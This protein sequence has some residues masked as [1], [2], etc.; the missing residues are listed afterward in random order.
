MSTPIEHIDIPLGERHTPH[1]WEYADKATREAATGMVPEDIGRW[2]K[3]LDDG[4]CWELTDDSPVTWQL[5][6][7]VIPQ[8]IK[9]ADYT[10][11]R[12]DKGCHVLHPSSDNNARTFTIPANSSVAFPIGTAITFVNKVNTVTIA[13]TTDTLTWAEDGS[14]GSRTL[15]A[16]GVCTALKITATEW[17]ISGVGLT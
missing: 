6:G 13:I 14:A 1:N 16:N 12:A 17:V 3:Q 10:F 11:V 5:T 15:A 2:A 7:G 8:I 4:S 9:S